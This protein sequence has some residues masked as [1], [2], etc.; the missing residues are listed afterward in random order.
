MQEGQ[1]YIKDTD[2]FLN[3]IK[4]VNAIPENAI[5]VTAEVVGFYPSIHIK[6]VWKHLD[7]IG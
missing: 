1:S 4:N 3:K 2:D 7:S 6:L 5:L